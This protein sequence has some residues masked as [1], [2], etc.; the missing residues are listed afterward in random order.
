MINSLYYNKK[1]IQI[2]L[3][4]PPC[5]ITDDYFKEINNKYNI[6]YNINLIHLMIIQAIL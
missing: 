3:F 1:N 6:H 4:S 5:Y 2:F